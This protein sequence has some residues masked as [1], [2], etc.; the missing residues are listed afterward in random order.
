MVFLSK[1]PP[2]A[3]VIASH[4]K[5]PHVQALQTENKPQS[6]YSF[7]CTGNIS[8]P[9]TEVSM[10][11]A[12]SCF[13][14]DQLNLLKMCMKSIKCLMENA[15]NTYKTPYQYSIVLLLL[16]LFNYSRV[17]QEYRQKQSHN[18]WKN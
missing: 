13:L 15:W 10:H 7:V 16:V 18:V 5:V 14:L 1:E 12:T 2:E 3:S 4:V 9:P 11:D 17:P 6:L 8:E